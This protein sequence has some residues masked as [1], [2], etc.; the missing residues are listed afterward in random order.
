MLCGRESVLASL[1]AVSTPIKIMNEQ[2]TTWPD[3]AASLFEKLT[4]RGAEV[5]YEFQNLEVQVP[6]VMG[7]DAKYAHWKLNGVLKIRTRE[8][9]GK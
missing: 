8:Q 1:V 6:N 3:F 7:P 5:T 9:T 2:P 4:G